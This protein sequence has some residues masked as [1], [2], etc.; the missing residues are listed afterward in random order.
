V[1]SLRKR[2]KQW[3]CRY[4]DIDGRQKEIKCGPDK[5]VANQMAIKLESKRCQVRAGTLDPRESDALDAELIPIAEHVADYVQNL[6]AKGCVPEHAVHV[7]RRLEWFL[8]E[9]K[10]G[11]L[12]QI[13]PSL[14][15]SALKA[16]RNEG[17]GDQT[18][19]H[20]A[21]TWKSFSKWAWKD[22]RTRTDFLADLELPRVVATKKRIDL[23]LEVVARVI[24]TARQGPRRRGMTGPDRS[25]L[26]LI[27]AVSGLRRLELMSLTVQSFDLDSSPATVS[28]PGTATKNS[29]DVV[30]P[31][32]SNIVECLRG[33][34]AD[35]PADRPLWVIPQNSAAMIR[36]DLRAAGVDDAERYDFHGLRHS[37]VSQVVAAGGSV[38][39]SMELARHHDPGLTF[40]RYA[41]ARLVELAAVVNR[42]PDM[43]CPRPAHATVSTGRNGTTS[44]P[45]EPCPDETQV[46]QSGHGD[47]SRPP[48]ARCAPGRGSI[49]APPR[50]SRRRSPAA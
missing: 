29:R 25:M 46:D 40:D 31:L 50:S 34:L 26:Y 47:Q 45:E 17:R 35:K 22:R 16:L 12:S 10:I 5:G 49:R 48:I 30:Q 21:T 38:K 32:P 37:F 13:R 15:V 9:T 3:Y 11:R 7:K 39:D 33:W 2:G 28:L 42:M 19:N 8:E 20:Y 1:A 43:L 44:G 23:P 24:E 6:E 14:A 18:V 27:A 4:R 41:H 36:A